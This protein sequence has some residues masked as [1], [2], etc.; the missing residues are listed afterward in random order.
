MKSLSKSKSRN[1]TKTLSKKNEVD[2]NF[3]NLRNLLQL[4][5]REEDALRS[6]DSESRKPRQERKTKHSPIFESRQEP[7]DRDWSAN[8]QKLLSLNKSGIL[9]GSSPSAALFVPKKSAKLT[10]PVHKSSVG[11]KTQNLGMLELSNKKY[12]VRQDHEPT[13]RKDRRE[14]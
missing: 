3:I 14:S 2:H 8:N 7:R 13:K 6:G 10:S 9:L 4:R 1:S 12:S 5:G 11:K